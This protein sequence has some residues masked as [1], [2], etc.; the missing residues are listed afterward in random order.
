MMRWTGAALVAAGLMTMPAAA[1]PLLAAGDGAW[2]GDGSIRTSLD[3]APEPV[4]CRI[5]NSFDAAARQL[6]LSGRCAV[7]GQ[8]W[9]VEGSVTADAAGRTYDGQWR[10]PR[11]GGLAAITGRRAGAQIVFDLAGDDPQT[12]EPVTGAMVWT[13]RQEQFS[14]ESFVET[15]GARTPMGA[16]VFRR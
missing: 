13:F 15:D 4:R 3:G 2:T 12:G 6:S 8:S 14:L 16:I 5:T 9:N 10:D 1:D 11:G 7:P